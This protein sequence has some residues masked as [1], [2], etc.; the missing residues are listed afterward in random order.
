MDDLKMIFEQIVLMAMIFSA[1]LSVCCFL[2]PCVLRNGKNGFAVIN[3]LFSYGENFAFLSL[4]LMVVY[5][6]GIISCICI[7]VLFFGLPLSEMLD[8]KTNEFED[9]EIYRAY[10]AAS[11]ARKIINLL[12]VVSSVVLLFYILAVSVINL[13]GLLNL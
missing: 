11:L 8:A 12:L 6:Y 10:A 2:I 4:C 5:F 3:K 1:V 9:I 7:C 13:N